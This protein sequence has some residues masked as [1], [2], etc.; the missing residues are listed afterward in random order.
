MKKVWNWV[1]SK[2]DGLKFVMDI[3]MDN[4]MTLM[5]DIKL[6]NILHIFKKMKKRVKFFFRM[7]ITNSCS[8]DDTL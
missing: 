2:K 4:E 5:Y 7:E 6:R 1:F 3:D 8:I